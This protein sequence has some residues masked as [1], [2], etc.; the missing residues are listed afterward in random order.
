MGRRGRP[1][2]RRSNRPVGDGEAQVGCDW[3][4]TAVSSFFNFLQA[5]NKEKITGEKE[6]CMRNIKISS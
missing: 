6:R 1:N 5:E 2:G 4:E 3:P